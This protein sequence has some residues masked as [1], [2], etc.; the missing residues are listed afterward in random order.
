MSAFRQRLPGSGIHER[1]EQQGL[2]EKERA[3]P[4]VG[5]AA[6]DREVSARGSD[7]DRRHPLRRCPAG[8]GGAASGVACSA[9]NRVSELS[10]ARLLSEL[11][12]GGLS[13]VVSLVALAVSRV[14]T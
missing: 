12:A 11:V 3:D 4:D 9:S 6:T 8:S 7:R 2:T 13:P 1:K 10:T 14:T 5:E